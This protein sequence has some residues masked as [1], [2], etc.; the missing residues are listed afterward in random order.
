[1]PGKVDAEP[2]YPLVWQS[3][4]KENGSIETT[5][6]ATGLSVRDHFAGLALQGF[7]SHAVSGDPIPV[8]A[9]ARASYGLAD[10][11]IRAREF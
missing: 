10:A 3:H 9:L 5:Y 1:M 6:A 2:A 4:V 7:L 11:M 8:E